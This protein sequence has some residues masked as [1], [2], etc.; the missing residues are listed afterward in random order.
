MSVFI[1]FPLPYLFHP[2]TH[3]PPTLL[4]L[5]CYFTKYEIPHASQPCHISYMSISCCWPSPSEKMLCAA[6]WFLATPHPNLHTQLK[7]PLLDHGLRKQLENSSRNTRC[8][9]GGTLQKTDKQEFAPTTGL[10]LT[11]CFI[12]FFTDCY[13]T[14][15]TTVS[16]RVTSPKDD[17]GLL[18]ASEVLL[19]N[20][21]HSAMLPFIK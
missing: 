2:L 16:Y 13:K 1:L 21:S 11:W 12:R 15:T 18:Q 10:D 17:T 5:S 20:L 14:E 3:L 6:G 19:I 8:Q 4:L 7:F 9:G